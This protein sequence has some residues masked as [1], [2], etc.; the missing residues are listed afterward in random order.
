MHTKVVYLEKP[1]RLIIWDRGSLTE[2][3]INAR[4]YL[5]LIA[6]HA[7]YDVQMKGVRYDTA[8][9]LNPK[10]GTVRYS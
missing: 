8:L 5:E 7:G 6:L 9:Q 1:K 3:K 2:L 4:K 10:G